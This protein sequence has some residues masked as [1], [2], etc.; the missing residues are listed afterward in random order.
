MNSR[1]SLG[2]LTMVV[3]AWAAPVNSQKG[4][5]SAGQIPQNRQIVF[6]CEHGAALSVVSAAYFNKLAKE[7][8]LNVHAIARGTAPQQDIA[9][10]AE[11]GLREDGV[12]SETKRPEALTEKDATGSLRIVA[13][14]AI[15]DE[16]SK[17]ATVLTWNDVPPTGVDYAAARDAILR[18]V[19]ELIRDLKDEERRR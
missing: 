5:E 14:C 12:V 8:H 1:I 4:S 3:A 13:F 19:R 17:V 6:V 9:A 18:H 2:V 10:S 7:E 11:K 15:P 16:Y